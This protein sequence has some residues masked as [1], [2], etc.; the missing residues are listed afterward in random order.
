MPINNF[1][2][3]NFNKNNSMYHEL[4]CIHI[5]FQVSFTCKFNKQLFLTTFIY[6]NN[7][8]L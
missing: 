8:I 3:I 6:D 1:I 2:M 7:T 4:P 5:Y